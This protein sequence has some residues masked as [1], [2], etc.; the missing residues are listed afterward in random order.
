MGAAERAR[1]RERRRKKVEGV[2]ETMTRRRVTRRDEQ[3]GER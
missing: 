1:R 3:V 2:R